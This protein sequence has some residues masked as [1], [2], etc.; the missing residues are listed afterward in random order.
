MLS[1]QHESNDWLLIRG[2]TS[3]GVEEVKCC[4]YVGKEVNLGNLFLVFSP[5]SPFFLEFFELLLSW[6][7]DRTCIKTICNLDATP[8]SLLRWMWVNTVFISDATDVK[9][10]TSTDADV[11]FWHPRMRMRM[12]T[13]C[14]RLIKIAL[15]FEFFNDKWND[16]ADNKT[17]LMEDNFNFHI[18]F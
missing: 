4:V 2:W 12:S 9:F 17:L 10:F 16:E 18:F 1:A 3:G 6:V 14:F 7:R 8:S 15:I 13:N 5:F 11:R